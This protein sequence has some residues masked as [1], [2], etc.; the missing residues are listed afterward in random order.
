MNRR[1]FVVASVC[2]PFLMN[3]LGDKS[4]MTASNHLTNR[5]I[6]WRRVMDDLSFEHARVIQTE[7]GTEIS[8]SVLVAQNGLPLRVDYC[9]ACDPSWQTHAIEVDQSWH[10]FR[11]KLRLNHDGSGHWQKDG[12][13]DST[14]DGCI[15]VDLGVSP[16]T[17]ALPVNRL[18]M[19]LGE[20]REINDRTRQCG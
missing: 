18:R 10:G 13:E 2:A 16:S 20:G 5:E 15:D 4:D 7:S 12:K 8:G 3:A 9:I 11:R 14:L 1:E 19:P 17:N 6:M